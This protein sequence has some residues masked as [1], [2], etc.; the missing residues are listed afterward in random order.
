MAE[1]ATESRRADDLPSLAF[2][3]ADGAKRWAKSLPLPNVAQAVRGRARPAARACRRPTFAPRERATIAEVMREPVAHLHTELARRYAGKPQPAVDRELEAAEQAIALW[4]ALWEQYSACLKPLLEGD[5]ELAGREGRSCCSAACTSASSSSSC[6]ASRGAFRRPTLWQELHA[7]YRLAEMLDARCTAVSDD[8]MPHA[9][10]ISCYST[11]S[12]ALLLGARRSVRDDACGRSSSPTAGSAQWARK[13]FPY[14][15]QR[16]TEGPVDR[17]RPRQR[18]AA[19]RSLHGGA[20][21]IR[22]R[23]C[24]SAIPASSR[25]ACAAG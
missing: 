2:A 21:R 18:R 20:A 6:T 25:P 1:T 5:A 8:L 22:R 17:R 4:Q 24:A 9:V 16:E 3:D 23:R 13:V 7:Y 14:A 19:R 11:Y 12:H 15:Q 10:G